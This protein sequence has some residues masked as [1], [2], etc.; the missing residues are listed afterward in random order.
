MTNNPIS[1]WAIIAMW[2][3]LKSNGRRPLQPPVMSSDTAERH[4]NR[5]Q[6]PRR[7]PPGSRE[8]RRR[9]LARLTQENKESLQELSGMLRREHEEL[10]RQL[11]SIAVGK[12]DV[13]RP[14]LADFYGSEI[15]RLKDRN[16]PGKSQGATLCE[17][18]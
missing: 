11:A 9:L 10:Q 15:I 17:D 13:R 12:P 14:T 16:V 3:L 6:Q 7:N 1:L 5:E 18:E 2:N 8:R 4:A